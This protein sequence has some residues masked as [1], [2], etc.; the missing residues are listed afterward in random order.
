MHQQKNKPILKIMKKLFLMLTSALLA[1]T[2]CSVDEGIVDTTS[3]GEYSLDYSIDD[4]GDTISVTVEG[5]I[6]EDFTFTSDKIWS[7]EGR[8]FVDNAEL[9]IEAGTIIKGEAGTGTCLLYTSDAAD[10]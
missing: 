4:N 2:S 6:D 1:F 5:T 10:D 9:T 8:V 3:D 7:L